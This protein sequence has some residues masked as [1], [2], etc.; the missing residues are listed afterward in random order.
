MT[1]STD[2]TSTT[3]KAFMNTRLNKKMNSIINQ[4]ENNEE[5]PLLNSTTTAITTKVSIPIQNSSSISMTKEDSPSSLDFDQNKENYREIIINNKKY[6][7]NIHVVDLD[8]KSI[9]KI[10]SYF[11]LDQDIVKCYTNYKQSYGECRETKCID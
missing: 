8:S 10:P 4:Q 6:R 2:S 1:Q 9:K 11:K 5:N 3:R 7:Y